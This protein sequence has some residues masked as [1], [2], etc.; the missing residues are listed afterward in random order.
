ME[1]GVFMFDTDE[2]IGIVQLSRAAE[3]RGFESV[4][5][6]EHSHIP[7]GF[8]STPPMGGELPR[9]YYRLLDPFVAL[10]AAAAVTE[11]IRLGTAV[12]LVVERDPITLAKE[13]SSV[14]QLSGGRFLFGIGAGWNVE[15]MA[16]HGTDA[17]SRFK[18]LRER[19]EAMQQIW[20]ADEAEYHGQLVDFAPIQAWPK[21]VQR[22]WPPV[23]VGGGGPNV[24]K[25]VVRYGDGWL[26]NVH[27]VRQ[28]LEERMKEL[29]ELA[30]AAGRERPGVTL[31]GEGS[32]PEALLGRQPDLPSLE[33]F[34][35]AGVERCLF[36]LPP[37][38]ADEVLPLLDRLADLVLDGRF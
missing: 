24:L 27:A 7:V 19:M 16:N 13:V 1:F 23:L 22:P 31:M 37:A 34:A 12:S 25:R 15:E 17:G 36:R 6:P 32:G 33:R 3:E 5:V 38:S 18:L 11:R 30:A 9:E 21:P 2:A 14:D 28:D 8:R 35:A 4:F 20:H 10:G 29:G 26:P